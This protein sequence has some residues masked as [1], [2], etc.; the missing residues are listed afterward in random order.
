MGQLFLHDHHVAFSQVNYVDIQEASLASIQV[1]GKVLTNLPPY[2]W[3][4][5][6]PVLWNEGRQSRELRNRKYGHHN[7]LGIQTLGSNGIDTT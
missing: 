7:L 2:P 6:G 3:T 1:Q 4:Y 5:D